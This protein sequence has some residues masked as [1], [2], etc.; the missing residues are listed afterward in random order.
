MIPAVARSH[1]VDSLGPFY[2][3]LT[4]HDNRSLSAAHK[5]IILFYGKLPVI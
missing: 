3:G 1:T 5:R 4:D 2:D